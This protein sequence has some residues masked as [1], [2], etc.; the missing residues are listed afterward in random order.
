[1]K[2]SPLNESSTG[3]IKT[4]NPLI[5]Q[6]DN[7]NQKS[8]RNQNILQSVRET[9]IQPG[10]VN[11]TDS[12][13]YPSPECG[14]DNICTSSSLHIS[15]RENDIPVDND[16]LLRGTNT[17]AFGYLKSVTD[18]S[19]FSNSDETSGT[20]KSPGR[21]DSQKSL[22]KTT[23]EENSKIVKPGTKKDPRFEVDYFRVDVENAYDRSINSSLG[24]A[25][26]LPRRTVGLIFLNASYLIMFSKMLQKSFNSPHITSVNL[27]S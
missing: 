18:S 19:T 7:C 10:R 11:I 4:N 12:F 27:F 21:Y 16:H 23:M 20:I 2:I 25:T 17:W 26:R 1:M 15:T 22:V 5:F 9:P 14:Q 24:Q 6:A 3:E 13:Q 8:E